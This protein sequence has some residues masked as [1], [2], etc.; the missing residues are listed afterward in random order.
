MKKLT[1]Q[2]LLAALLVGGMQLYTSCDSCSRTDG[3]GEG[4]EDAIEANGDTR[5]SESPGDNEGSGSTQGTGTD[6]GN[7]ADG[8]RSA[9]NGTR[10]EIDQ[11]Q[12]ANEIENSDAK[13][14]DRNGNPIS[15]SGASGSGQGT[16][17]GSTGNNSKVTSREDQLN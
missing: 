4:T 14:V 9:S 8:N 17:T 11:A 6:S 16:G 15:S 1:K 12:V 10:N 3:S 13:K 2:L 5:G 7:G